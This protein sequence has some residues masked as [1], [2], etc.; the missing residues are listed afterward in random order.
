MKPLF[1]EHVVEP[2]MGAVQERSLT[3]Y[4]VKL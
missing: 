4:A 1:L 3:T 2:V